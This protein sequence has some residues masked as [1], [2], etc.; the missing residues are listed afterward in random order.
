VPGVEKVTRCVLPSLARSALLSKPGELSDSMLW[1]MSSVCVQVHVTVPPTATV[2][3][4]GLIDPLCSLLKKLLPMAT[5]AV[6]G[7]VLPPVPPPVVP[8]VEPPRPI[9]RQKRGSRE[10]YASSRQAPPARQPSEYV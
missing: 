10:S 4:A 9:R 5:A 7:A 1:G 2:S 6:S 8:P 3:T